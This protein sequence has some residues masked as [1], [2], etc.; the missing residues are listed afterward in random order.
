MT[1]P[2]FLEIKY[3]W[4]V[5]TPYYKPLSEE[6]VVE[7]V[8]WLAEVVADP[9]PS[10]ADLNLARRHFSS[11]CLFE[12]A[13][14]E[15]LVRLN[16]ESPFDW[17]KRGEYDSGWTPSIVHACS[18][19]DTRV[20]EWILTTPARESLRNIVRDRGNVQMH[21]LDQRY[22]LIYACLERCSAE[23]AEVLL[24]L[25]ECKADIEF[26]SGFCE[27]CEPE[28]FSIEESNEETYL[29]WD[30]GEHPIEFIPSN[31]L[32]QHDPRRLRRNCCGEVLDHDCDSCKGVMAVLDKYVLVHCCKGADD[33][34]VEEFVRLSRRP[35][36]RTLLGGV[37]D[38]IEQAAAK[39]SRQ[40]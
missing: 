3:P 7:G 33:A 20:L 26:Y 29:D 21:C 18:N 30:D 22:P 40:S 5:D 13:P 25:P 2:A 6:Q 17:E 10:Q 14:Y 12:W 24:Q 39:R 4:D 1:H 32:A 23:H 31:R 38:A 34:L 36:A 11:G 27:H 28:R 19:P 8:K 35:R 9:T 16:A 37:V 15:V